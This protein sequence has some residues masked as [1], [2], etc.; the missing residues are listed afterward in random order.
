MTEVHVYSD[1]FWPAVWGWMKTRPSWENWRKSCRSSS[2]QGYNQSILLR[3]LKGPITGQYQGYNHNRTYSCWQLMAC[4]KHNLLLPQVRH[5]EDVGLAPR[6]WAP[7][8]K[9]SFACISNLE[10]VRGPTW[11]HP[12]SWWTLM[13]SF[14]LQF[15]RPYFYWLH[16]SRKV[17]SL[18]WLNR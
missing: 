3:V 7:E 13:S 16:P 18:L 8:Q 11:S 12:I 2:N 10:R 17:R 1:G 14:G 15:A 5:W 9:Y 6:H 4:S